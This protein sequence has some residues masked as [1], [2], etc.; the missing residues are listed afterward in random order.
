MHKSIIEESMVP[1][2]FTA[3]SISILVRGC[4]QQDDPRNHNYSRAE[5]HA[6]NDVVVPTFAY[7]NKSIAR[8]VEVAKTADTSDSARTETLHTLGQSFHALQDF[9]SHSNYLEG[10]LSQNKKLEP[11]NW[12]APPAG[13][14]TCYYH[15]TPIPYPQA[16]KTRTELVSSL[17]LRYPE[18]KFHTP[19][20]FG[21]RELF[22]CPEPTVLTYALA[23]VAFTHLEL[24]KDNEKTLEGSVISTKYKKS[25]F[26]LAKQLA[27]EDTVNAW[28]V[29]ERAVRRRYRERADAIV[30]SLKLCE[31]VDQT[32]RRNK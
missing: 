21:R 1:S 2:G 31:N 10:L 3:K 28:W 30:L 24:S 14:R 15:Y 12:A 11:V 32:G 16:L 13:V 19:Q 26:Y 23:P 29:F 18:L 8:A 9:Y 22:N 25:Y 4:E 27:K 5:C 17:R 7:V 6:V 20:E